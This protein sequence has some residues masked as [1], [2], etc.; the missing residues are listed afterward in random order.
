ME[1]NMADL[2]RHDLSA[3]EFVHMLL[4]D[5]FP[6]CCGS[7]VESYGAEY[8]GQRE[9][10]LSC[11][12]CPEPAPL[13]DAQIVASLRERFP[14]IA[15]GMKA[16]LVCHGDGYTNEGDPEIGNALFDCEACSGSGCVPA[17]AVRPLPAMA[18]APA[19]PSAQV[20]RVDQTACHECIGM[21]CEACNGTGDACG[22]ALP[23]VPA[24]VPAGQV[25]AWMW[26]HEETGRVGFIDQWQ[27]ENGWQAANPRLRLIRPLVFAD[28]VS[29]ARHQTF[30]QDTLPTSRKDA[31]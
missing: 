10:V 11:C 31:P 3:E 19:V 20:Q 17:A 22:G 6:E 21:G 14:E 13:S 8:F 24:M 26:Q 1:R 7:P 18:V 23:S 30:A 12:G 9:V 29:E 2:Q 28:G 5:T 27:I 25:V 15:T 16:C 4:W